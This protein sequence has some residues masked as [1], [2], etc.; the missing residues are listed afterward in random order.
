[1][2]QRH[3]RAAAE[4]GAV[5]TGGG[6]D[7]REGAADRERIRNVVILQHY[8][9]ACEA[10]ARRFRGAAP[11]KEARLDVRCLFGHTHSTQCES[12]RKATPTDDCKFTMLVR[13]I[14][15]GLPAST[16]FVLPRPLESIVDASDL[17]PPDGREGAEGIDAH[18]VPCLLLARRVLVGAAA[19]TTTLRRGA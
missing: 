8:P 5:G 13:H 19:R 15:H 16:L 12:P 14:K 4:A 17:V 1:V 3:S 6:G 11:E 9:G 7:A 18:A 10:L 2:R